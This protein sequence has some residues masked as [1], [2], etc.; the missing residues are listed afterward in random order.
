MNP[1]RRSLTAFILCGGPGSRLRQTTARP[2]GVLP[3]AGWP[4]LRYHTEILR[5]VRPERVVFLTGYGAAEIESVFGPRSSERVFLREES[6]L[7]TGGALAAA[8]ELTSGMNL[9][10]N[11]DSFVDASLA[12]FIGQARPDAATIV[13]VRLDDVGDYGAVSIEADGRRDSFSEKGGIG[14]GWINAGVYLLP[15]RF[16]DELP[17]GSSNLEGDTFPRWAA[18]GRLYAHAVDAFFRDIGTPER[19]EA[20]QREFGAIRARLEGTPTPPVA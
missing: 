7:G 5:D 1:A 20:A 10:M 12:R 17:S 11:G 6:R 18:E 8:R 16:V 2:K 15:K 4:F 3:V 14:A 9:V 19:L 13:A